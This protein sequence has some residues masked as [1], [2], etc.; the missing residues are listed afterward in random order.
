LLDAGIAILD[1]VGKDV[2]TSIVEGD[3]VTVV[4]K[5]R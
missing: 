3:E 2:M 5:K 1:N 4:K